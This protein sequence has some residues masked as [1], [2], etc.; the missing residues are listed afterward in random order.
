[1]RNVKIV[2]YRVKVLL[3]YF[4]T[5]VTSCTVIIRITAPKTAITTIMVMLA[6]ITKTSVLLLVVGVLLVT[7]AVVVVVVVVSGSKGTRIAMALIF[8]L[9]TSLKLLLLMWY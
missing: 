5:L 8:A 7:A 3:I 2:T 6:A 4:L 1:M 9:R